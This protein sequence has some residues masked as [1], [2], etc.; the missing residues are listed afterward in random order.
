MK[1][2]HFA[3]V[4]ERNDIKELRSGVLA[5]Y[6]KDIPRT[7]RMESLYELEMEA[8]ILLQADLQRVP[9]LAQFVPFEFIDVLTKSSSGENMASRERVAI[10]LIEADVREYSPNEE[11][12]SYK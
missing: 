5:E 12:D 3:I 8:I 11:E 10:I 9:T 2:R 7:H 1:E 6:M 4:T